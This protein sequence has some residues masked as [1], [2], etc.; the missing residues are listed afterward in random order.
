MT[1]PNKR[2]N[3]DHSESC[4]GKEIDTSPKTYSIYAMR[5][6]EEVFEPQ[7]VVV[8]TD[9]DVAIG[10]FDSESFATECADFDVPGRVVY[11]IRT[12]L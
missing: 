6:F 7:W 2:Q 10:L 3:D 5:E 1:K 8:D 11:H 4:G 12:R 9:S